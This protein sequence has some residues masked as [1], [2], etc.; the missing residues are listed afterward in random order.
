MPAPDLLSQA[1]PTVDVYCHKTHTPPGDVLRDLAT[2]VMRRISHS[3]S[4][5]HLGNVM[6]KADNY[7]SAVP[8]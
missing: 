7:H 8:F 2:L 3:H 4:P 1:F 6:N 5:G